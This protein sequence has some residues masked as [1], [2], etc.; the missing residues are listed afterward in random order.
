MQATLT[1][2]YWIRASCINVLLCPNLNEKITHTTNLKWMG[3]YF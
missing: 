3:C 1:S 2:V